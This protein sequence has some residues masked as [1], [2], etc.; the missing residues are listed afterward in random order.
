MSPSGHCHRDLTPEHAD[1]AVLCFPREKT[2][3][4]SKKVRKVWWWHP[5][6]QP[7]ISESVTVT[8]FARKKINI[9]INMKRE[10]EVLGPDVE[11]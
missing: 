7:G 8:G 11:K 2:K 1:H 5:T 3:L 9:D 4:N 10:I 6:C